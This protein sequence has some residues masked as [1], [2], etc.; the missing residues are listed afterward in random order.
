MVSCVLYVIVTQV[1]N[2]VRP[3]WKS[4]RTEQSVGHRSEDAHFSKSRTLRLKN[5]GS[6]SLS[7]AGSQD[8]HRDS[9]LTFHLREKNMISFALHEKMLRQG[10][11][12]ARPRSHRGPNTLIGTYGL[13]SNSR[14]P[15]CF[16]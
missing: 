12:N 16:Q 2:S 4:L 3:E 15:G 14:R 10:M 8:W 6:V 1:N 11:K 13:V 5:I 9:H 7:D